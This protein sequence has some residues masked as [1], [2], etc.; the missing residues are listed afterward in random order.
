MEWILSYY[1]K[2]K[3]ESD[4]IEALQSKRTFL[5]PFTLSHFEIGTLPFPFYI[6]FIIRTTRQTGGYKALLLAVLITRRTVC[7]PHI[8]IGYPQRAFIT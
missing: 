2:F 8:F 4:I 3:N 5:L 7:Q 1:G 6:I